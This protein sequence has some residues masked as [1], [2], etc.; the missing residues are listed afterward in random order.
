[1]VYYVVAHFFAMLLDLLRIA[2][3][4]EQ[5]KDLELLLLRQHLRI[6]HRKLHRSPRI[7]RWEKLTLAVLT[8]KLARLATASRARLRH[9]LLF[10]LATVLQWHRELVRRKWSFTRRRS[11]G[12]PRS[13]PALEALVLRL[14]RENPRWG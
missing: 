5:Q 8:V 11:P 1:M 2:R 14:A 13:M 7:T 10:T 4:S 6:V 3:L 9:S 12:R